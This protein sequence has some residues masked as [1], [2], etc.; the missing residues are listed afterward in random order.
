MPLTF[1]ETNLN[2]SAIQAVFVKIHIL[3]EISTFRSLTKHSKR[4]KQKTFSPPTE[5]IV[6]QNRTYSTFTYK[7]TLNKI[8]NI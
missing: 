4:V 1:K 2:E 8:L 5:K 6:K 3:F 7:L